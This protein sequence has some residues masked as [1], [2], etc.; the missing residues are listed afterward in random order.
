MTKSNHVDMKH[1]C[2]YCKPWYNPKPI[3]DMPHLL[4]RLWVMDDMYRY[5][6]IF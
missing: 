2:K 5:I 1:K 6:Q 3:I 4:I